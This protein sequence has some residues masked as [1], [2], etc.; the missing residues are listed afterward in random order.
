MAKYIYSRY[1]P[2]NTDHQQQLDA[3]LSAEPEAEQVQ[4]RV[5]GDVE[6]FERM[7]FRHMFDNLKRGDRV[8]VWWLTAFG[9]DFN[10][11][12]AT[13][14]ALLDKGVTLITLSEPL[15]FIPDS[16]SS[17]V[18]L[19]L[20]S[21]YGTVQT[22]RRLLAAEHSR[23]AMKQDPELWQQ[24]FRGRPADREK[25]QQ[26]AALLLEG[27]KLQHVADSCEVSIST[28]KRVKSKLSQFDD[29]GALR[30]RHKNT[31]HKDNNL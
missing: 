4:D 27:H 1:S 6:P 15:T 18:L 30:T 2:K 7:G 14:S 13:V 23:K 20:L 10:Q 28:V 5:R 12:Q 17:R 8:W 25:H 11:V 31:R 21:G 26:I 3:L 22:R 29:E 9:H 24:K 19:S 16:E